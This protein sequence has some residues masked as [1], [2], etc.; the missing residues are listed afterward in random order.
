MEQGFPDIGKVKY[1]FDQN[2]NIVSSQKYRI[3]FEIF[4]NQKGIPYN[5]LIIILSSWNLTC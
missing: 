2:K 3:Y 1:T 5:Y 4:G